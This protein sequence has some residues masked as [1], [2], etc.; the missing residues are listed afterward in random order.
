MTLTT[1]VL[2]GLAAGLALGAFIS[3][4]GAPVLQPLPG[5]IEPIGTLWVNALR[6]TV[7]P[8]VVS[9][10]LVGVT[11]LPD[12]RTIGRVGGRAF[13]LF[14]TALAIAATIAIVLGPII[15]AR[16]PIDEAGAAALRASVAASSQEAV[17]SAQKM[18]TFKQWLVETS[19][20][21]RSK[22]PQTARCC[23]S[24]FSHSRS[25]SASRASPPP[26]AKPSCAS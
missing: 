12:M 21:T 13:V 14:I 8:L 10:I 4:S 5:W 7:I 6:M 1:K 19:R 25:V 26:I 9:A 22:P 3:A 2:I 11:S 16:L 24:S 23:R 18:Q 20:R 17:A 15:F